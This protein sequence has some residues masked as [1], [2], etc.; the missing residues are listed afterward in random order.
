MI[1]MLKDA[2]KNT[3]L[4]GRQMEDIKDSCCSFKDKKYYIYEMKNAVV[5]LKT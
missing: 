2:K 5:N 4:L 1:N 3:D